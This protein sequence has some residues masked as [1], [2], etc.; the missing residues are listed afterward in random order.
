MSLI[1]YAAA[2]FG[3]VFLAV[4]QQKNVQYSRY[5]SMFAT[6]LVLTGVDIMYIRLSVNGHIAA[7]LIVGSL[8]N[9]CAVV[10][11]V[12]TF[13]AIRKREVREMTKTVTQDERKKG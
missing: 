8:S 11:A 2:C 6:S 3:K 7:A 9:A 10:A 5:F 13:N 1:L 12:G 4:F